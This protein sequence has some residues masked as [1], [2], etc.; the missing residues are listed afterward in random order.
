LKWVVCL[1]VFIVSFP[2]SK[3]LKAWHCMPQALQAFWGES[4]NFARAPS[5][6]AYLPIDV[7]VCA[8]GHRLCDRRVNAVNHWKIGFKI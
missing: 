5:E 4:F 7:T 8:G 1:P 2:L 6:N 3:A